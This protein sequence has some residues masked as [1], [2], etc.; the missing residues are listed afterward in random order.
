MDETH[1][2]TVEEPFHPEQKASPGSANTAA[3]QVTSG[4]VIYSL[5]LWVFYPGKLREGC[6]RP[7]VP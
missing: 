1:L 6:F 5:I 2:P 4:L 3:S 7:K